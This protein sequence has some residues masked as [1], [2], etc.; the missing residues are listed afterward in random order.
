MLFTDGFDKFAQTGKL[1][2]MCANAPAHTLI[3]L[4]KKRDELS[5]TV[6]EVEFKYLMA[7]RAQSYDNFI[8][9]YFGEKY[10][11]LLSPKW[12]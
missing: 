7:A 5:A 12:L 4:L 1:E 6:A 3:R 8:R 9:N 10:F 11:E 2:I